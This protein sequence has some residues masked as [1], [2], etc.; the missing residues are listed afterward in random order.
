MGRQPQGRGAAYVP[1]QLLTPSAAFGHV[2]GPL[3]VAAGQE[4]ASGKVAGAQLQHL[5]ITTLRQQLRGANV[6][7]TVF[8]A[9][10]GMSVD[11]LYRVMRGEV[12]MQ[13]S[14]LTVFARH[15]PEVGRV[16]AVALT[17]RPIPASDAPAASPAVGREV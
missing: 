12:M 13:L 5:T 2:P 1:H 9:S 7:V 11:R 10:C 14:D 8:A 15:F 3:T 4:A 17:Q 6:T 16:A